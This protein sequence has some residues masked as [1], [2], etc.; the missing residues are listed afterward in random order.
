MASWIAVP[1]KEWKPKFSHSD[2]LKI[3]TDGRR[4][5]RNEVVR[6][7]D[8]IANVRQFWRS[9]S[10]S[11]SC[12]IWMSPSTD[13]YLL[14]RTVSYFSHAA[15]NWLGVVCRVGVS[16]S[17]LTVLRSSPFTQRPPAWVQ[18]LGTMGIFVT[19]ELKYER[20]YCLTS[21]VD[22]TNQCVRSSIIESFIN[23]VS[24]K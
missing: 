24:Q 22:N 20:K 21:L 14:Y 8:Q 16:S 3:L 13:E 15:R 19:D 5:L 18:T 6:T 10:V 7:A 17:R 23:L 9:S 11:A 4:S 12:F 2:R 1:T